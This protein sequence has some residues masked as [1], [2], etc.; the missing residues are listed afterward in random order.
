MKNA[1]VTTTINIPYNLEAYAKD[2]DKYGPKDT[3]IIIAG[4]LKTPPEIVE[5]CSDLQKEHDVPVIYLSPEEQNNLFFDYSKS[6]PWNCVERRNL[7]ILYAYHNGAE[8]IATVDDD[9]FWEGENYFGQ[10]SIGEQT[11]TEWHMENGWLNICAFLKEKKLKQFFPRGYSLQMRKSS[12]QYAEESMRKTGNVVVNAGLWLGEP[13]IDAVTRLALAPH[14][15]EFSGMNIVLASGTI[16]PFNSQNT[17]LHRDVIPAYC[18][19]AGTGRY[20]DIVASYIVKRIADHL[21]DYIRFG[22]PIVRQ[23]RNEHDI[24]E[25]LENERVGMQLTDRFVDWLY[26]IKLTGKDYGE[27]VDE[28]IPA[29]RAKYLAA[30]LTEEQNTFMANVISGY[31]AWRKVT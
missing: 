5:F 3:A 19:P 23:N 4:D 8:I 10:H 22:A 21:G 17:A 25:D 15:I 16:C 26:E 2:I 31:N 28:L 24:W 6:L 27:C 11:I 14:V 18:N 20:S 7:A 30:F 9:N 1:L 29:L 12:S 13:D